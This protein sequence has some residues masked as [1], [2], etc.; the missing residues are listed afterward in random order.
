MKILIKEMGAHLFKMTI[1]DALKKKVPPTGVNFVHQ[2]FC[3]L[4]FL[5]EIRGIV[6]S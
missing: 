4:N 6:K 2:Q 3:V 5:S 1:I